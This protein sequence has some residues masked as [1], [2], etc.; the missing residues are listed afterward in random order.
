MKIGPGSGRRLPPSLQSRVVNVQ[1]WTERFRRLAPVTGIRCETVRFDTQAPESPGIEGAEC[2]QGTLAGYEIRE[3]LLE[4]RD[5][6]CACCGARGTPLKIDHV[7]EGH[8]RVRPGVQPDARLPLLQPGQGVAAGGELPGQAARTSPAGSPR[9][10]DAASRRRRGQRHPPRPVRGR[11]AD[12]P[13]RLRLLGRAHEVQPGAA[14]DPQVAFRA[15][16][17]FN[18][19]TAGGTA[20]GVSHRHCRTVQRGDRYG[21]RLDTT[22]KKET[23]TMH[24]TRDPRFLPA[25]KDGASC[26]V[27]R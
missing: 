11:G 15:S 10:R 1:S 6:T 18:V 25:P 26:E 17:S 12:R 16:G 7:P 5:R 20:Q 24:G 19:Q 22:R 27:D 4:K 2:Q 8:G 14:G 21:C 9:G 13:S 23:A 3:C